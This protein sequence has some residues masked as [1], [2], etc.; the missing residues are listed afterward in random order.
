MM[1]E[2]LLFGL[3]PA[4]QRILVSNRKEGT[5]LREVLRLEKGRILIQKKPFVRES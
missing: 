4:T 1:E 3:I 5:T 2:G